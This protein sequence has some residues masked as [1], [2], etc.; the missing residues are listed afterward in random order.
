MCVCLSLVVCVHMSSGS[1]RGQKRTL[2]PRDG[3]PRCKMSNAGVGTKP[4]PS[5]R[6]TSTNLTPEPSFQPQSCLSWTV[7]IKLAMF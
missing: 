5:G 6:A 3:I 2:D 7:I 4:G 1:L